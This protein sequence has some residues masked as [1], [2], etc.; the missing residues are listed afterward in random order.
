MVDQDREGLFRYAMVSRV[1]AGTFMRSI[2]LS[3]HITRSMRSNVTEP[4]GQQRPLEQ[5]PKWAVVLAIADMLLGPRTKTDSHRATGGN[6]AAR[7]PGAGD[8]RSRGRDASRLSDI[9]AKGWKDILWRV[10]HNVP[11]HRV[12]SIEAGVTFYVLL[13]IFPATAALVAIYGLFADPST[14]GQYLNELS[15]VLPAGQRR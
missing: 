4:S 10:Y 3:W 6:P 11:E 7:L 15:G 9:P 12:V 5:A 2:Q 14:I 8:E 1:C 13:S